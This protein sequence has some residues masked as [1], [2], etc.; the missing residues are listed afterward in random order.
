[1]KTREA[2][3][4]NWKL[5]VVNWK[6]IQLKVNYSNHVSGA[7]FKPLHVFILCY[8]KL[9][10]LIF[11]FSVGMTLLFFR[12]VTFQTVARVIFPK[13]IYYYAG[14]NSAI[15]CF[16]C[17]RKFSHM[18]SIHTI[19][20]GSRVSII[21]PSFQRRN[22]SLERFRASTKLHWQSSTRVHSLP[23][24]LLQW[25]NRSSVAAPTT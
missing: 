25:L 17:A 8:I 7:K 6:C 13:L 2:S 3:G 12:F 18:N 15:K 20:L 21:I 9:C 10:F 4:C 19:S 14:N 23:H 5:A 11:I 22:W 16:L 1:M 24:L